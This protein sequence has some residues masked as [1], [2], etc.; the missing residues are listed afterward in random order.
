MSLIN[1]ALKKAQRQ[2]TDAPAP[3]S[4]PAAPLPAAPEPGPV[5]APSSRIVKRRT[6]MPASTLILLLGGGGALLVMACVFVFIF[7]LSDDTVAPEH[8]AHRPPVAHT[9]PAVSPVAP[10]PVVVAPPPVPAPAPAPVVTVK[11]PPIAAPVVETPKPAPTPAPAP[12]AVVATPAPAIPAPAPTPTPAPA[13]V[14]PTPAPVPVVATPSGPV[15]NPA[16]HEF[17]EKLRVAGIRASDTDPKVIMNDRIY[18]LNDVVDRA[19]QLRLIRV[20]ASSLVFSD[21]TGFVYRKSL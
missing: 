21:A 8:P 2:R 7:F 5:S 19:T 10:A 13:V 11:L 6:P 3:D 12:V 4:S 1:E 9:D 20:E 18:R 17:L 16:V 14:A 15:A